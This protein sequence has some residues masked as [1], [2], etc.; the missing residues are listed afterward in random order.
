MTVTV[1]GMAAR[2]DLVENA[3]RIAK[4]IWGEVEEMSYHDALQFLVGQLAGLTATHN[5]TVAQ[6]AILAKAVEEH[7]AIIQG[8][9]VRST[10]SG[11]R[12]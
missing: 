6:M 9:V 5:N 4:A 11:V 8:L 2:A 3:H 10:G 12:S 7:A 1:S